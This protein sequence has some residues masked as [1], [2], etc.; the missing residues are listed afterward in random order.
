MRVYLD[1]CCVCRPFDDSG[2]ERNRIEAEAVLSVLS[3]VQQGRL[4]WVAGP[5]LAAEIHNITEDDKRERAE[6]LIKLADEWGTKPVRLEVENLITKGFKPL[7]AMHLAA[8]IQSDCD[9]FLST[10]DRLLRA[11]KRL[12]PALEIQVTNPMNFL[13]EQFNVDDPK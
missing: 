13:A 2:I 10:D 4:C 7:D 6:T 12:T 9:A 11:A 5:V 1:A 8:A 3:L